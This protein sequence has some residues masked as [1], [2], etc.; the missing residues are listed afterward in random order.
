MLGATPIPQN[1]PAVADARTAGNQVKLKEGLKPTTLT[2]DFN[3]QE[4]HA[5]QN[6]FRTNFPH[7]HGGRGGTMRLLLLMHLLALTS[8]HHKEHTGRSQ[9]IQ[10]RRAAR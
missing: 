8:R 9:H 6:T 5:W 1:K 4:F 2:L 10:R 7:E 3:P